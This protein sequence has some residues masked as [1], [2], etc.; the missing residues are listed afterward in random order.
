M[1]SRR[2]VVVALAGLLLV[3]GIGIGVGG[4]VVFGPNTTPDTPQSV[5]LPR[6]V[7]LDTAIDS[8]QAEGVLASA[9]TFRFLATVTGWGEQIKSGHYRVRGGVS[10]YHLLDRL[11]RG[12]QDPVRLTI[13][14]GTR[15]ETMAKVV[16]RRLELSPGAFRSALRD[17]SLARELGTTPSQLFGY[18]LP[19][20]YE[21]Y[22]Q[23]DA[24][25]VVRRIKEAFDRYYER[26]LAA[27]ADSLGLTKREVVTLASIVEWEALLDDEKPMIS[28]VYLNR[29]RDGW[30]LQADPTIQYVLLQT[31]G[32]R[33]RRVLYEDLEIDH[34]YNTY[35][36]RGLPPGPITNPS[37]SSLRAVVA[38]TQHDYYYFAATGDGGHTFSR[39]LR[40]HN[41]AANEYQRQLEQRADENSR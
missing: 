16:G 37:P 33:T 23:T 8:L 11:R 36:I 20:T 19:E 29:L 25:R 5:L 3:G 10:N 34:P 27:G 15:P 14:P 22:W 6:D 40:E 12:L 39:T 35:Q 26:R 41:R 38:P 13:P 7:T 32:E 30:R 9:A 24:R 1:F 4:L 31:E 18:L 17:T 28:G 21:F 2:A